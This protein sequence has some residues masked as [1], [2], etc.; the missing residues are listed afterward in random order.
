[1]HIIHLLAGT[2]LL[3]PQETVIGHAGDH[4]AATLQIT[5]DTH[6]HSDGHTYRLLFETAEGYRCMSEVLTPDQNRELTFAVPNVLTVAGNLQLQ[7]L[8]YEGDGVIAHSPKC[9]PALEVLPAIETPTAIPTD[10][11]GLVYPGVGIDRL[12][13]RDG[14]LVVVYEDGHE[15]PI[16]RIALGHWEDADVWGQDE[17]VP[18]YYTRGSEDDGVDRIQASKIDLRAVDSLCIWNGAGHDMEVAPQRIEL[19]EDG[20][21]N[22]V[23]EGIAQLIATGDQSEVFLSCGKDAS[24]IV[25]ATTDGDSGTAAMSG[26][27]VELVAYGAEGMSLVSD[28]GD[29]TIHSEGNLFISTTGEAHIHGLADPENEWDAV[30]KQYVDGLVG[31]IE[32]VLDSVIALQNSLIGGDV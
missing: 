25:L 31:D 3:S 18:V 15:Q 11:T 9:E 1:M 12:V 13:L 10:Y 16:G 32:S 22:I 27:F 30:N 28:D 20:G 26:S 17:P 7:L 4:L 2:D 6:L 24:T 19:D 21:V 23:S 5:L 14:Q 29:M 8:V